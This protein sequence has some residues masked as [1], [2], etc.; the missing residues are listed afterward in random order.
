MMCVWW[1]LRLMLLLTDI[2]L[3]NVSII[4]ENKVIIYRCFVVTCMWKRSGKRE[5]GASFKWVWWDWNLSVQKELQ[6]TI[7]LYLCYEKLIRSK[8]SI[9]LNDP[10]GSLQTKHYFDCR[11]EERRSSL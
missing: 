7:T 3:Q 2:Y 4:L 8:I 1:N 5:A 6:Q 11:I 9:Q 10:K